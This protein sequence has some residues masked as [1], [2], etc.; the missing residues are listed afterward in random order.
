MQVAYTERF[1]TSYRAALPEIQRAFDRRL[2]LLLATL[3]HPSLCAK[4]FDETMGIWQARAGRSWRF[5]FLIEGDTYLLLD[6]IAHP[7]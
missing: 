4:E 3:R 2:A 6:I 5:Y 1:R 7:K